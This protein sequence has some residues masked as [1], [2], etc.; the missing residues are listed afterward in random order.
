[1]ITKADSTG[2]RSAIP[3]I[4]RHQLVERSAQECLRRSGYPS[5]RGTSCDF[6]EGVLTIRGRVPSYYMKQMAQVLTSQIAEVEVVDNRL[7]VK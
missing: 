5:L 3:F 6:H 7:V 1:M 2:C 4:E